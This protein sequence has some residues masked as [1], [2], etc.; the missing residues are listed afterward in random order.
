MSLAMLNHRTMMF[1]MCILHTSWMFEHVCHPNFLVGLSSATFE[2]LSSVYIAHVPANLIVPLVPLKLKTCGRHCVVFSRSPNSVLDCIQVEHTTWRWLWEAQSQ[3]WAEVEE[4]LV[5]LK[6]S[7]HNK[8]L[9]PHM[10][11]ASGW[12]IR[13]GSQVWLQ[14]SGVS[15]RV[16]WPQEWVCKPW[17]FVPRHFILRTT[18][19]TA[20]SRPASMTAAKFTPTKQIAEV[21]VRKRKRFQL[22]TLQ[23]RAKPAMLLKASKAEEVRSKLERL[24]EMIASFEQE[25]SRVPY[26]LGR[27]W[28]QAKRQWCRM[29]ELPIL[30]ML[31]RAWSG[32]CTSRSTLCGPP[33]RSR[34][35]QLT[36]SKGTGADWR[37][38]TSR[39]EASAMSCDGQNDLVRTHWMCN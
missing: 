14:L 20:R 18:R 38:G 1:S 10:R 3:A 7:K 33:R 5:P 19:S 27:G 4:T 16:A 34:M 29:R 9:K 13:L 15:F 31:S 2:S 8:P 37:T 26:K 11:G 39:A 6:H 32:S 36:S 30:T 24:E 25:D 12:T 23:R 21:C 17:V 22:S 28:V 35:R